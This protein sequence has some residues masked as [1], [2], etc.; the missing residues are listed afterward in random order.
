MATR[1]QQ[2][3]RADGDLDLPV[4]RQALPQGAEESGCELPGG[5]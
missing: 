3:P 1:G 2:E 4:V 5:A